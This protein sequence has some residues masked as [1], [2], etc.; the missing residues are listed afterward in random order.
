[1]FY[2][3]TLNLIQV[4]GGTQVKQGD[5]GSKFSYKLANEKDHELDDFDKEVA[6]INLVLV[7]KIVFTT[8]A[9]VDNST[10]TFNI[11]KAIPAGLYFLEIKI[12]DYI[13]PSD[14][15][16]IIFVQSGAVAYD[17][18][19]LVPNYDI[20]MTIKGILSDLSQKGID[21]SDLN[22]QLAQKANKDEV[23]NVMTPK[24]TLAYA[25]L[26]TS[27]NQVGW[28]YYCPDGD[29]VHGAGN[30][31]WN[32]T[33]WFFGGTGD[34]GYNLLKK[35]LK[36]VKTS[37]LLNHSKVLK[38]KRL[39][40]WGSPTVN[41]YTYDTVGSYVSPIIDVE[42][43]KQYCFVENNSIVSL[44]NNI[45]LTLFDKN[46]RYVTGELTPVKNIY[47]IP[48]NVYYI[49]FCTNSNDFSTYNF[50]E[51]TNEINLSYEEY[52]YRLKRIEDLEQEVNNRKDVIDDLN[53]AVFV[54]RDVLSSVEYTKESKRAYGQIGEPITIEE[55]TNRTLLSF[56][57][58][59][60]KT[61]RVKFSQIG[62]GY[63]LHAVFICDSNNKILSVYDG[64]GAEGGLDKWHNFEIDIPVNET[65]AHVVYVQ[66]QNASDLDVKV[67]ESIKTDSK[68]ERIQDLTNRV[69]SLEKVNRVLPKPVLIMRFDAWNT[70]DG[71]FELLKQ[72]GFTATVAPSN[73]KEQ[74][75]VS[76]ESG[77]DIGVYKNYDAI[78][79]VYG[80]D[81]FSDT[82]SDEILQ[83][84]DKYVR[85]NL[86]AQEARGIYKPT[87]W[88]CSKQK[89]CVGLVTA[90]K[91]YGVKMAS[92]YMPD[93][94]TTSYL[95]DTFEFNKSCEGLYPSTYDSVVT[96]LEKAISEGKGFCVLTHGILDTEE[97]ANANYSITRDLLVSFFE[98]VKSKVDAGE[99]LVLNYRQLYSLYNK[100]DA[101]AYDFARIISMMNAN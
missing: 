35:D 8:T 45:G 9:T 52:G 33:S 2:S 22:R 79:S 84:W 6:H 76:Q 3:N 95:T 78:T 49:A 46:G 47:T 69:V 34:E 10:V 88:L 59:I 41:D 15:Q 1:M 64:E 86:S 60:G 48:E 73:S 7:D 75:I 21:I 32:G 30:Y 25:S 27:G 72:Y 62:N 89:S 51:Y 92:G 39:I 11:D 14:K 36:Y 40:S 91:K 94:S 29:G 19:E 42:P 96:K 63:G 5:L 13:F 66:A 54:K 93:F 23:T 85:D 18:K 80:S 38:D 53:N 17:L 70:T 50:K 83:V 87:A 77:I 81:A 82:P 24:G 101:E 98:I 12:R 44:Y 20:N 100:Y 61:Y 90:L 74:N 26:P 31:V 16:T 65:N 56:S 37:N 43:N 55:V 68:E 57:P 97:E 28:Y 67:H 4:G 58:I 99:L 71:R